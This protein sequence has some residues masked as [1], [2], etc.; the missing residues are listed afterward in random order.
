MRRSA[1]CLALLTVLAGC[2]QQETPS[3]TTFP[4]TTTTLAD[5][6]TTTPPETTTTAP[7][8]TTTTLPGGEFTRCD[9]PEGFSV[10]YPAEWATN[11]GD[12]LPPCSMFN[13]EPFEVPEATDARPAA[14]FA[15][16]D[17]V[18]YAE[19]TAPGAESEERRWVTAIDGLPAVRIEHET[20]DEGLYPP[21]T[22]LTAYAVDLNPDGEGEDRT[23][24]LD[25]VGLPAFGYERNRLVLDRMAHT[26]EVTLEGVPTSETVVAYYAGGGGAF[27]VE[28][29]VTAGEAC[30]RIP[31]E[32]EEVC[33]EAPS[34]GRLHTVQLTELEPILAGVTAPEVFRVTA[35]RFDGDPFTVL[36]APVA[37]G[38]MGGLAFPFGL[39][40]VE[41]L[42]LYDVAG[43][44]LEVVTPGG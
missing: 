22:R 11:E 29:E 23:L 33:T 42:V 28:T 40:A 25:T 12:A 4:D 44:E 24:F 20:G 10:A 27:R 14:I 39:D 3:E 30:L 21:G 31:P 7:P 2:D 8:E 19:A 5:T 18:P 38:E 15:R 17:P 35:H 32:G 41:S 9:N 26:V 37:D 13:V 1:I 36:P 16:I 6:T 34:D 43:E